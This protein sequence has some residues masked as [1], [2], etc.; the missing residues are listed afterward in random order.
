MKG[1]EIANI[2]INYYNELVKTGWEYQ[3]CV[4]YESM[5]GSDIGMGRD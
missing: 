1:T 5:Y 3:P 2:P 4:L